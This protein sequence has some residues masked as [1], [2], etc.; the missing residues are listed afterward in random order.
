[1]DSRYATMIV[2]AAALIGLLGASA[3]A[4]VVSTATTGSDDTYSGYTLEA[5]DLVLAGASSLSNVSSSYTPPSTQGNLVM[6]NDGTFNS[7]AD[8]LSFYT[9]TNIVTLTFALNTTSDPAGYNIFSIQSIAGYKSEAASGQDFKV[10]YS[11]VA[12]PSTFVQISN[13]STTAGDFTVGANSYGQSFYTSQIVINDSNNAALAT[14][15]ADVELVYN[16]PGVDYTDV[17][18]VDLSGTPIGTP[19]PASASLL[20]LGMLPFLRRRSRTDLV[21]DAVA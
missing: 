14:G 12:L 6:V 5:N 10:Y 4:S 9:N 21:L 20:V 18:E 3:Q 8:N 13:P 7:Y 2:P 1:M 15:V 19:E 11:T 17:R 16:A